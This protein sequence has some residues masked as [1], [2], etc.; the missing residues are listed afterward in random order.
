MRR[1]GLEARQRS[2]VMV[3][4]VA[5]A[6]GCHMDQGAVLRPRSPRRARGSV[7]PRSPSRAAGEHFAAQASSNDPPTT[8]RWRAC[9]GV[10]PISS[11]GEVVR[12]RSM[13]DANS[14]ALPFRTFAAGFRGLE[15]CRRPFGRRSPLATATSGFKNAHAGARSRNAARC[16]VVGRATVSPRDRRHHFRRSARSQRFIEMSAVVGPKRDAKVQLRR[17]PPAERPSTSAGHDTSRRRG[18]VPPIRYDPPST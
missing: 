7:T 1:G 3:R 16:E 4:V 6:A 11:V 5:H 9:R 10:E 12:R 18:P 14:W 2:Q 15:W 17:R 13:S 8:E